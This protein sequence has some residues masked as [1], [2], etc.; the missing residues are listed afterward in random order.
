[1]AEGA[2]RLVCMCWE[3]SL[4]QDPGTAVQRAQDQT[5]VQPRCCA[6][7]PVTLGGEPGGRL[8]GR[9]F[10][11]LKDTEVLLPGDL[12]YVKDLLE[13]AFS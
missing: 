10:H 3:L 7:Q 1:M 6:V 2:N 8:R 4:V 5:Q 11:I 12:K 9:A 13:N